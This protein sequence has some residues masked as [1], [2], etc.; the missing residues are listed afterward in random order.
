MVYNNHDMAV[1]T[2]DYA[3]KLHTFYCRGD[4]DYILLS[5]LS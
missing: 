2:G 4:T 3:L 5:S 1:R